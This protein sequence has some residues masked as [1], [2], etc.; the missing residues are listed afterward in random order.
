MEM[1]FEDQ[2]V[3]LLKHADCRV[4]LLDQIHAITLIALHTKDGIDEATRFLEIP[5]GF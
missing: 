4:A 3:R 2:I 1:A 5:L